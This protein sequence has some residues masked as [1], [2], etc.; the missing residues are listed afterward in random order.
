MESDSGLGVPVA[1]KEDGM[2]NSRD[3]P[4]DVEFEQ[5]LQ[6]IKLPLTG[7]RVMIP[8][9]TCAFFEGDLQPPLQNRKSEVL[10][11][12]LGQ[13]YMADMTRDKGQELLQ[14]RIQTYQQLIQKATNTKNK[15]PTNHTNETS[16]SIIQ[17]TKSSSFQIKKGFLQSNPT[18]K[19]KKKTTTT[20]Q[21]I[22][23]TTSTK[24]KSHNHPSNIQSQINPDFVGKDPTTPILPYIEIREEYDDNGNQIT[25]KAIDMSQELKTLK[26]KIQQQKTSTNQKD[27]E[28]ILSTLVD[29]L[30][31]GETNRMNHTTMQTTNEFNNKYDNNDDNHLKNHNQDHNNYTKSEKSYDEISKR[32]DELIQMEEEAEKEK[33]NSKSSKGWKK[34]FL[35]NNHDNNSN[36]EKKESHKPTPT[37]TKIE[38]NKQSSTTKKISIREDK[39]E[40]QE[41]PRIGQ[42]SFA[43]LKKQQ[44]KQQQMNSPTIM[45]PIDSHS[46]QRI[47]MDA[48]VFNGVIQE[49]MELNEL[50]N[51]IRNEKVEHPQT[52]RVSR[53]AQ[54]R[55]AQQGL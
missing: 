14:R 29:H 40:V 12:N 45:K 39:N 49:R 53:F 9:T 36:R 50:S 37:A 27:K 7:Q 23:T 21:T 41:I 48:N 3:G 46:K 15:G 47:P 32:L 26:Q 6:R 31:I 11:M 18:P 25:S 20:K 34:G 55:R 54:Q 17:P 28:T 5:V 33:K 35:N 44:E 43:A 51:P 4:T 1:W 22:E 2:E 42:T 10:C 52:K 8:I 30:N 19:K 38:T 13:G 16:K 24:Q